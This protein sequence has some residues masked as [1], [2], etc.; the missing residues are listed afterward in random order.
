[1]DS[2]I[3]K[4]NIGGAILAGG[5][6][7]RMGGIPKG[8]LRPD[9]VLSLIERLLVQAASSGIGEVAIVTNQPDV[10]A[11]LPCRIICDRR[12]DMGPVAGVEAALIHFSGRCDA[13][14]VLPCDLPA[15]SSREMSHLLRAYASSDAPV[16][17][18]ETADRR[19]HP[20][21][22]VVAATLLGDIVTAIERG[23]T[24][25][26][27]LWSRLGGSRA[28][29]ENSEAFIN[30]NSPLDVAVWRAERELPAFSSETI[31]HDRK[32]PS[33]THARTARLCRAI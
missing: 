15:F 23:I 31:R 11:H 27:E 10:Y 3:E 29:F 2:R 33:S 1:M 22:A 28:T 26:D 25:I 24:R 16:V 32:R 21:C 4:L 17:S 9:G 12:I 20:L 6:A 14:L 5:K 13:V 18:A 19:R 8:M 30:L 7:S